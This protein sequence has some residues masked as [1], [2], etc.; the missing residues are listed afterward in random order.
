MGVQNKK[1][2]GNNRGQI[3]DLQKI[4]QQIYDRNFKRI[5]QEQEPL[6]ST[7]QMIAINAANTAAQL[8]LEATAAP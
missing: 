2:K 6:F 7:D 3:R 8:Q 5:A 4:T 1:W